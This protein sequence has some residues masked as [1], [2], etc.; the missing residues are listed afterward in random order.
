MIET[1]AK[2]A[3]A[4]EKDSRIISAKGM[5]IVFLLIFGGGFLGWWFVG[6]VMGLAA[7]K[8]LDSLNGMA[9]NVAIA[10]QAWEADGHDLTGL[11]GQVSRDGGDFREYLKRN[12]NISAIGYYA[13]VTDAEGNFLYALYCDMKIDEKYLTT[14]PTEEEQNKM[15]RSRLPSRR[16]RTVGVY[17]AE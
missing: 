8:K 10:A 1:T 14:P 6:L 3:G 5:V 9:R 16:A 11:S 12:D 17:R 13:V 2:E 7:P 15:L 4:E